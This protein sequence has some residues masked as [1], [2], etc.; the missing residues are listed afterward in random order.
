MSKNTERTLEALSKA[1]AYCGIVERFI[2]QA[3]A[4]KF[5]TINGKRMGKRT[6]IRKDLFGIIDI[7]ALYPN[8]T[9]ICGVQSCGQAFS[10]HKSKIL[11]NFYALPWLKYADLELWAWRKLKMGKRQIWTPRVHKFSLTDF[12]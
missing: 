12:I 6:G 9:K 11:T 2:A 3:G 7:I 8:R 1:G 5:N 10:E 4:L